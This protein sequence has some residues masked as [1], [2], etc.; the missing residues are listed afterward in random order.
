MSEEGSQEG[1]KEIISAGP[2]ADEDEPECINPL[3]ED[4]IAD[5]LSEIKRT[6]DGFAFAFSKLILEEKKV[7]DLGVKLRDYV[8]LRE[9][10]L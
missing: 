4:M 2:I 8:Y 1:E 9:V 6:P 5:C 10:S 7:D 3:T